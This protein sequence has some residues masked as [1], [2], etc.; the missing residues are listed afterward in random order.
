MKL[1]LHLRLSLL[2]ALFVTLVTM[3]GSYRFYHFAYNREQAR[4]QQAISQLITTVLKTAEIA[5][6]TGN[7]LIAE[8]VLNGLSQNK[9][10]HSVTIKTDQ[11]ILQDG[12]TNSSAFPAITRSLYSPF[13]KRE[14]V[15]SLIV[16]PD[17]EFVQQQ[18]QDTALEMSVFTF[19][20][21]ILTLLFLIM[22]IWLFITRPVSQLTA[23]L[24]HIHPGDA[25]RLL[26]PQLLQETELETFS[27]TVNQLLD[28]V[29]QQIYD[30]K[31]LRDRLELT[32]NNFRTVFELSINA[33]AITDRALNLLAYNPSFQKMIASTS[34]Q[35]HLL[36][37]AEWISLLVKNPDEFMEKI[38]TILEEK[39]DTSFDVK[40]LSQGNGLRRWVSVTAK[41]AINDAGENVILFFINDIT[42]QHEA[43]NASKH[44]ASHD[45]LTHLKNRRVAEQQMDQMIQAASKNYQPIALIVI[46]LDGFKSVNDIEG[47]DAGDKVL[48]EVANRLS[49]LTRKTDIVA[50]W[51]GDEFVLALADATQDIARLLAQ[52]FLQKISEPI[53]IGKGKTANVGASI[54]IA[55]CPEHAATFT[56]AFECADLAMYQV[57]QGGK[58]GIRV[59]DPQ[60]TLSL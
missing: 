45:H 21:V 24:H 16:T 49:L 57:K 36:H 27:Q 56:S 28:Q 40:L 42:R 37:T 25:K 18:A 3:A 55:I 11:Y 9:L 12:Q 51:G 60:S 34:S 23:E 44:E 53:D 33:L 20:I 17:Q 30:E 8:D 52:R 48:I 43:L 32:A 13:G 5:A 19:F 59:Y 47:H 46:D 6:Y 22:V 41:E 31:K 26:I 50:R 14:Y 1:N 2:V 4:S 29:Q 58:R 39:S 35:P 10:I 7:K 38:A 15:G 54:G